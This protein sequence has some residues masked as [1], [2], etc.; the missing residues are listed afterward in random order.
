MLSTMIA[1]VKSFEIGYLN[2]L[3]DEARKFLSGRTS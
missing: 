1:Q 2:A 3:R